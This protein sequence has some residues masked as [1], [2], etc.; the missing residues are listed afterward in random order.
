MCILNSFGLS[1]GSVSLWYTDFKNLGLIKNTK[2]AAFQRI[3]EF[4]D[5]REVPNTHKMRG[6]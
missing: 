4:S 6:N 5:L 1:G 3:G 2:I